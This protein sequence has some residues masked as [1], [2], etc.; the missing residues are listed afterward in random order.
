MLKISTVMYIYPQELSYNSLY[1]T[2]LCVLF[3]GLKL[4]PV[5][6]VSYCNSSR[7]TIQQMVSIWAID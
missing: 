1:I 2:W 3:C 7:G 5:M 6:W 4:D